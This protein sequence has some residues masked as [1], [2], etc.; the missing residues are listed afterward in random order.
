MYN[1][2]IAGNIQLEPELAA[3]S[4]DE[5]GALPQTPGLGGQFDSQPLWAL[6][7]FAGGR[8]TTVT[9]KIL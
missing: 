4:A 7:N 5:I 6:P 8:E 1:V 2:L 3:H 9:R